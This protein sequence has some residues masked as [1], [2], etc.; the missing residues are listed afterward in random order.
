MGIF[1]YWYKKTYFF[2]KPCL[3]FNLGFF[4]SI[5]MTCLPRRI[6]L[7]SPRFFHA[8]NELK[9]FISNPFCWLIINSFYQKSNDN[10]I[11]C[12]FCWGCLNC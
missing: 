9:N 4:G 1:L 10:Y 3:A 7:I 11:F 12:C 5:K 6:C 2:L 8:F